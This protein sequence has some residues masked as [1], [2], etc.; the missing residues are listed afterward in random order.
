MA[1]LFDPL[2]IK[3]VELR[4]RIVVSPMC[5]YS[6][7]DGFANEWHLVHLGSRAVGGAG[8][9]ITEATAVSPEGRISAADLGIWKNAHIEKLRN[10]VS[11]LHQQGAVAGIQL[12]H[13]GRKA[14]HETPWK[15]G[16][17][18][19]KAD[20]GWQTV[21]PS[22]IP[23]SPGEEA[24]EALSAE[25]VQKVITDFK[26]AAQRALQA[27]FRVIEIHGAH[28]YLVH[29]FLSPLSNQRTDD[30]G[31]SFDN[32]IRLL[33]EVI[34]AIQ[35]VWP[36]TLPLFVRL[37][38]TDWTEGGWNENDTVKLAGILKEKGVDLIDCSTGGLGPGVKISLVPGYQVPFA[39][40]V[41][42]EAGIATGAVGL[43]TSAEQAE[44]I[45]AQGKAD[46]IVM[47]R[48]LLR[49]PYFPLHAAKALGQEIKWPV[50]YERAKPK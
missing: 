8:L 22:A 23:F 31:G 17:Q 43:I 26:A 38:C 27:G 40:K 14:S 13:A 45:L 44:D 29:E 36:A 2:R 25:G 9:I 16:G 20:G 12:A 37:S 28:G 49:D 32:R 24:P 4:N 50:Q 19:K 10:V 30:Y 6:S 21:A 34:A 42:K 5:E 33:L 41:K 15:G 46:V 1:I 7:T 48:E 47:A 18:V 3:D 39:E 35:T 11:F